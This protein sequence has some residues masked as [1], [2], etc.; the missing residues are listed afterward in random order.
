[1]DTQGGTD[2]SLDNITEAQNLLNGNA[3]PSAY[4]VVFNGGKEYSTVNFGGGQAFHR[5]QHSAHGE[6][7][8]DA[9]GRTQ[10]ALRVT[11]QVIIP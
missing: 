11:A 2:G 1:V 7:L 5:R 3:N 4:T 9:P 8:Q 6:T 10:Y